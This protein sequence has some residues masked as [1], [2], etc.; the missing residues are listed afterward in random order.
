[1]TIDVTIKDIKTCR[2]KKFLGG[3]YH[4]PIEL[5]S[6]RA[7]RMETWS[8]GCDMLYTPKDSRIYDLPQEARDFAEAFSAGVKVNPFTFELDLETYK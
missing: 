7:L 1:M 4:C 5:A 2:D 6:Q 8:L 3:F